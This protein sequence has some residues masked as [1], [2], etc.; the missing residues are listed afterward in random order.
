MRQALVVALSLLVAASASVAQQRHH[1]RAR[2]DWN[3][4]LPIRLPITPQ[5][6]VWHC[7]E[8]APAPNYALAPFEPRCGV[9]LG[10]YVD[11]DA[12]LP[13]TTTDE[14]GTKPRDVRRFGELAGKPH[15]TAMA[16]LGY[17][18]AFPRTWADELWACGAVPQIAWEP[19]GGLDQVRDDA[20]LRGFAADAKAFG[21]PVFLRFASEMNGAWPI[22]HGDPEKYR[23]AFRLVA[24]LMHEAAP[25]VI[26]VW[27]PY[28]RPLRPLD[29]YYPGDEAVDWVGVNLYNVFYHG[30]DPSE[31]AERE[32]PIAL[33]QPVYDKYAPRKPIA[34]C[35]YAATHRAQAQPQSRPEFAIAKMRRLYAALPAWFPRVKM[36][37]WYDCDNLAEG[38]VPEHRRLN[39]YSLTTDERVLAAYREI[40]AADY[41]LS[42]LPETGHGSAP[43]CP[44]LAG[45]SVRVRLPV[46]LTT[47]E[48][49]AS[50]AC[51]TVM[52][53]D[54]QQ[55]ASGPSG[56]GLTY[57]LPAGSMSPGAHTVL[58]R[59]QGAHGVAHWT[60]VKL[61]VEQ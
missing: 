51:R 29:D 19:N 9:L 8:N 57:F 58:L 43:F 22:Y 47:W 28:C 32:D 13:Y 50:S 55:V 36:I 18:K 49:V 35:E 37:T 2:Q 11:K 10:A 5:L 16:Y 24:S 27:C 30:A 39:D 3:K 53:I 46:R 4:A 7:V 6:V 41:F 1:I 54:G 44:Q 61:I 12:L 42:T 45:D 48:P 21:Q 31:R 59:P 34:I 33:L 26:M 56:M 23:T 25:N 15:G 40:I 17:G 60:S 20:Y 14:N 52:R 38:N